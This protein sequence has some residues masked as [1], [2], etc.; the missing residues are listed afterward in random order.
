MKPPEVGIFFLTFRVY[1]TY[2]IQILG[3]LEEAAG[4]KMYDAKR[5]IAMQ[6][7]DKKQFKLDEVNQV[8]LI[9]N[10]VFCITRTRIFSYLHEIKILD[11]GARYFAKR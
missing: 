9:F 7:I 11:F 6:T 1:L 5:V 10:L 4:T 8:L 2:V 3:M